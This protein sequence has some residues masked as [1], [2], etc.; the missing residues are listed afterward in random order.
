MKIFFLSALLLTLTLVTNAKT[1]Y[2]APN[3]NDQASGTIHSP[4]A[5]LPAAYKMVEPGDTVYFRGGVY[6]VD[7][8]QIMEN[9][10]HYAFV[11]ALEKGGTKQGR[12]CFMGY[13]DERPVFDFSALQLNGHTRFS[14]FY[15]GADY[16]HLRNFDI[17]G[18]PVRVKGHT[19][20]ECVSARKGSYC[21]VENIAMHD[22]MAI[23][24]YQTTGSHNLVLN[25]DA[26]NNY[27]DYSEG[28]YGG[29]TDGFGIHVES[30]DCVGNV[31]RNCRAWRNSDDGF[32]LIRCSAPVEIDHCWAFYN[33][34]RSTSDPT[35][36]ETFERAG[37]GNGFKGGGWGMRAH[38]YNCP[39]PCPSHYIHDCV[40]FHNKANG[41]YANHHLGGNRWE[42]NVSAENLRDNFN[43]VNRKGKSV[44]ECIDVPGYGHKLTGNISWNPNKEHLSNC[45]AH[46]CQLKDNTFDHNKN[47]VDSTWF[48]SI[49][50]KDVFGNLPD[51]SYL[52]P[53][54]RKLTAPSGL[55]ASLF[56]KYW[57]IEAEDAESKVKFLGDTCEI[58]APK[59]LTLWR[60]DIM[61]AGTV[62]EY[63]A[64]VMNNRLSDM[65]FFWLASDPKAKNIWKRMNWRKG[66]FNRCYTLQMYYLGY[67]GNSNRTTRFRRYTGNED[68]VVDK[69]LRPAILK[70]YTD[71][72]HLLKPDHWYHVKIMGE[73]GHVRIFIDHEC[74]MD[75]KDPTPLE[76][77]WF[78][79]RTTH[80]RTRI[81]NF[82][83][84]NPYQNKKT[85]HFTVRRFH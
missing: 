54:P 46:L 20:S 12:T 55:S 84:Y 17:V 28:W 49:T 40:A 29:N 76:S 2:V 78:G 81:T 68:A 22:G 31:I 77:G 57:E 75:Y 11:F 39:T 43:M 61:T 19:Q 80:S 5:T 23:G 72:Q 7:D 8:S 3:G 69:N 32:D 51:I 4:L 73:K 15:L 63:D 42:R 64:C 53:C 79:F 58:I 25:C 14:A 21:I 44:N 6:K 41:F 37:D 35:D 83:A 10:G 67:G 30:P 85:A 33:G 27:D 62:I 48:V 9:N 24:Y 52:Q 26:Y 34:F 59:G 82:K 74:I 70:E 13:P 65:N 45:D 66:V 47:R 71:P 18:V 56:H 50:P 36:T 38:A 16:L 1:I 60:K